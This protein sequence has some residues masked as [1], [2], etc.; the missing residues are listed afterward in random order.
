LKVAQLEDLPRKNLKASDLDR[1][2]LPLKELVAAYEKAGRDYEF[3]SQDRNYQAFH[4]KITGDENKKD[5]SIRQRI[6]Q[7]Y[8]LKDGDGKEWLVYDITLGAHDWMGNLLN[9]YYGTIGKVTDGTT[10]G[11]PEFHYSFKFNHDTGRMDRDVASVQ[12]HQ[13]YYT[14][15]FSKQKLEELSEFFKEPLTFVI[16][17]KAT[18]KKYSCNQREFTELEYQEL[19]DLKTGFSDYMKNKTTGQLQPQQSR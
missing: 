14:I 7:L 6:N 4:A 8:R 16:V 11:M 3:T 19:I 1:E 2:I 12:G 5:Q 15:P 10:D 13:P 17:D 9:Y 18:G